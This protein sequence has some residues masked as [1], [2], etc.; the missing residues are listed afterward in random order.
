MTELF[1][2]IDERAAAAQEAHTRAWRAQRQ[3][4]FAKDHE[5]AAFWADTCTACLRELEE[6]AWALRSGVDHP[7]A[8]LAEPAANDDIQRG[9][10]GIDYG[11]AIHI[12]EGA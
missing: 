10:A 8:A 6:C 7:H 12:A 5:C 4:M 2:T 3:A 11:S 9:N 1:A